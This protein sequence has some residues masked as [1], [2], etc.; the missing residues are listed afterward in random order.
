MWDDAFAEQDAAETTAVS[1][2]LS[3]GDAG[4]AGDA[5]S[6]NEEVDLAELDDSDL[7]KLWDDAL[8]SSGDDDSDLDISSFEEGAGDQDE[9]SD[10]DFSEPPADGGDIVSQDEL[11]SLLTGAGD[12]IDLDEEMGKDKE[13][14]GE[15]DFDA[16]GAA[17]PFGDDEGEI[18]AYVEDDEPADAP[19]EPEDGPAAEEAQG[20]QEEMDAPVQN[21]LIAGVVDCVMVGFLEMLF[22]I[23]T[24]FIFSQ[25]T[26]TI[27]T[28]MEAMPLVLTINLVILLL[29]TF[30][31]SVYFIGGWGGTPGHRVAGLVVVDLEDQPVGYMQAVLRYF[32]TLIAVLP[33]GLGQI[34]TVIDKKG[35]GLGD[36]L[37]GTKVIYRASL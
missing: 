8:E 12:G 24:H 19:Q 1:E 29:L 14:V 18:E 23:G 3:A 15:E 37:A 22:V 33:A 2:E 16:P 7:E 26:D 21:R 25:V 4:D 28:N 31:Y 30:F 17:D 5:D 32:G 10:D 9:I 35:R 36:R 6:S 11:D 20:H 27:Y 13:E 34:L